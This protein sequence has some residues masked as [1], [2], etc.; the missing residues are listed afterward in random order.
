MVQSQKH[1]VA[2]GKVH[3]AHFYRSV[4]RS[5]AE[6]LAAAPKAT[7]SHAATYKSSV[8]ELRTKNIQTLP[9]GLRRV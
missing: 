7:S 1:I 4:Y 6:A 2:I 8:Y 9:E 5:A 3:L